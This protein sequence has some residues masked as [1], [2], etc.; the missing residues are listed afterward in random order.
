MSKKTK[1]EIGERTITTTNVTA[2]FERRFNSLQGKRFE[3]LQDF[4][5]A[6]EQTKNDDD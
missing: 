3:N 5:Q 6:L 4:L 2:D 1:I